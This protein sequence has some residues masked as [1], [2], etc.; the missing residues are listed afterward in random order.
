MTVPRIS[1]W[2][3]CRWPRCP[4]ERQKKYL[5]SYR[6][7]H[8]HVP[9]TASAIWTCR[10]CRKRTWQREAPSLTRSRKGEAPTVLSRPFHQRPSSESVLGFVCEH[11]ISSYISSSIETHRHLLTPPGHGPNCAYFSKRH[12]E[13]YKADLPLFLTFR[14]LPLCP[15][16]PAKPIFI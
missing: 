7:M 4:D 8:R 9:G 14:T 6:S 2:R 16:Q 13:F 12:Q 11:H 1:Q 5:V 10:P 15:C 3:A